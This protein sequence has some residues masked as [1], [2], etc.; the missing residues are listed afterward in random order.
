VPS[1]AAGGLA[2]G[3][4]QMIKAGCQ[5]LFPVRGSREFKGTGGQGNVRWRGRTT[6]RDRGPPRIEVYMPKEK[7]RRCERVR[8]WW[9]TNTGT[10]N[11]RLGHRSAVSAARKKGVT[12]CMWVRR[13]AR[14]R[15]GARGEDYGRRSGKED[16]G[17]GG[18]ATRQKNFRDSSR[19][20]AKRKA[21]RRIVWHEDASGLFQRTV[22]D[23]CIKKSVVE[24]GIP[25]T[26]SRRSERLGKRQLRVLAESRDAGDW[27]VTLPGSTAKV[28]L[29]GW[30]LLKGDLHREK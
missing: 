10:R 9:R 5:P 11:K 6:G 22:G 20:A 17:E 29:V 27:S 4:V 2:A 24:I 19:K 1:E 25:K 26:L 21:G 13:V 14:W 3:H 23:A 16:S 15:G 30:R 18:R 8:Q 7:R 28:S 12:G